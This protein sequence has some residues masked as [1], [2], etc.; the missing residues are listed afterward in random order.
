[1]EITG[2][3]WM[4]NDSWSLVNQV[5]QAGWFPR[6]VNSK[7]VSVLPRLQIVSSRIKSSVSMGLMTRIFDFRT[8]V[9]I[10]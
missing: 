10:I 6:I 8:S 4:K 9:L 5:T 3:P 2:S 1:M 7:S